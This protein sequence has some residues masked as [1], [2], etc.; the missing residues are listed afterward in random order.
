M[1][2]SNIVW[3]KLFLSLFEQDDR[4]LYQLN[5]SQQLLYIKLLY[6]AGATDNKIPKNVNFVCN[7]VN[8]HHE[9]ACFLADVAR[10]KA[11]FP[12]FQE[13]DDCYYFNNFHELHNRTSRQEYVRNSK[14]TPKELQRV[15]PEEEEEQDKEHIWKG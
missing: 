11:V 13:C 3:I 2:Y 7:K 6:L 5:E 12:R 14:G 4:F 9:Q 8:Y 1:P 10:I 15:T